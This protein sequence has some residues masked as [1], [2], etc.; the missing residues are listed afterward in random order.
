ME[1]VERLPAQAGR[2]VLGIFG[3][4]R[5]RRGLRF[6]GSLDELSDGLRAIGT[7]VIYE[8]LENGIPDA[9]SLGAFRTW[10]SPWT[11]VQELAAAA[12]LTPG[13]GRA[14]SGAVTQQVMVFD[15]AFDRRRFSHRLFVRGECVEDWQFEDGAA[16]EAERYLDERYR[17]L[18]MRDWGIDIEDLRALR[19]PFAPALLM[20]AYFLRV[21]R[22]VSKVWGV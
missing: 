13:F 6:G 20:E 17:A 11:D 14:L 8:P 2:R 19:L 10:G 7:P 5:H 21:D 9:G 3:A 1:T 16:G 15:Y 22:S 4:C 18:K 12:R